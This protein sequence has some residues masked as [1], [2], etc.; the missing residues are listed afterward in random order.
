MADPTD[1]AAKADYRDTVFL[2]RTDFPMRAGLPRKEPEILADWAA[3][4][5]YHAMR[6]A[7]QAEGAPLYVL[8]DGPPYRTAEH[9]SELQSLMR[10]SYA[11]F[12]RKKKTEN[13]KSVV[14]HI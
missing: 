12:V 1:A 5:L 6:K 11:L 13:R 10:I 2:P 14:T 4:G 7:R 9:T 3:Q 8:H